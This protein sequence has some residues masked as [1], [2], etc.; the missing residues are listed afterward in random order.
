M[1]FII[2]IAAIAA[3]L[4]PASAHSWIEELQAID[5]ATGN[6]TGD[7]GYT[8]GYVARTDPGFTGD[9]MNYLLPPLSSGRT[10][11]D[12][13]DLLCHPSQRTSN[14]KNAA[15]PRLKASPGSYVAMKYLENGHVTLPN[16]QKGKPESGGPI[17]V[18]GTT[19]PSDT[20][21]IADVLAWNKAGSGGD[22]RGTLLAANNF[23]DGRC[24]Q[25]NPGTISTTRQ[26]TFADHIEGQPTSSVEQWCETDMQIPS[27]QKPG[28]ILTV[29]WVWDWPTAAN[30]DPVYP[31][32]KDEFYTSC[33]EIEIV[34]KVPTVGQMHT[35]VQQDPQSTAVSDFKSRTAFTTSPVYT[36]AGSATGSTAGTATSVVTGSASSSISAYSPETASPS[37]AVS[38][39]ST[40][41]SSSA[42]AS[43]SNSAV[44]SHSNGGQFSLPTISL[45]ATN[46]FSR[47]T[48]APSAAANEPESNESVLTITNYVTISSFAHKQ[49]TAQTHTEFVTSYVT[50]PTSTVTVE[51]GMPSIVV[52]NGGGTPFVSRAF[53]A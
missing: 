51:G 44:Y 49:H 26:R 29:Y 5:S 46:H 37:S 20:E 53:K 14:Y 17:F 21:K 24:H 12:S 45:S 7:Y 42:A 28:D 22:K 39:S 40:V 9:S 23:D 4:G 43:P 33:A 47:P 2:S 52:E 36:L 41:V 38:S 30:Q 8:R 3:C 48:T 6:Y 11:I 16:N 34:E 27:S 18:Y 25:I 19:K 31:Q 32:G 1:K 50:A 15:Y 10:R 13:S 35:L